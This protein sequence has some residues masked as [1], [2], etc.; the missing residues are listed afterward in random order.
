MSTHISTHASD[1]MSTHISSYTSVYM[2]THISTH[3]S[4]HINVIFLCSHIST[5]IFVFFCLL[6]HTPI[7]TK[8]DY[9]Y[10]HVQNHKFSEILIKF[11]EKFGE[12]SYIF[13]KLRK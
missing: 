1:Y 3:T 4:T 6:L 8:P 10:T 7:P 5:H 13:I 12:F 9:I 11:Q 2:T